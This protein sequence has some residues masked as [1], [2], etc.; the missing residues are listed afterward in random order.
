MPKEI[1]VNH[2]EHET[3]IAVL[4]NTDLSNLFIERSAE[5]SI[6]GNIY[7]G[8]VVRV[9]PGMQAAFVDIGLDRTAFLY[10][11]DASYDLSDFEFIVDED[12]DLPFAEKWHRREISSSIEDII[13]E[14]QEVFVQVSKEPFGSKGARITT[15]ISLAGRNLVLMPTLNHI[16]VS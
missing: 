15:H 6:A 9:L 1:I 12:E 11:T 5:K 2:T 7:M 13:K 10:V 16:G 8:K 4:D 3:R 14:G